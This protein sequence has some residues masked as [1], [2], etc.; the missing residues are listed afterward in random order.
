MALRQFAGEQQTSLGGRFYAR[1]QVRFRKDVASEIP[2]KL[3]IRKK[4]GEMKCETNLEVKI[5]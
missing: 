5:S 1:S 2:L 3:T 4:K